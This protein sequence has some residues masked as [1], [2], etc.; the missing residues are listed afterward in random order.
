[1]IEMTPTLISEITGAP[2]VRDLA[3]PYPV[4]HLPA[5]ADL[6]AVSPRG[7]LIRWSTRERI[8]SR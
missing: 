6:V 5:S 4:D 1:M 7:A 8:A 2:S 3:Y